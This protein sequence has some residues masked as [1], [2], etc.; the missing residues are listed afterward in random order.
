DPKDDDK[1][2]D[3]KKTAPPIVIDRYHFKQDVEGYLRHER[4]HLYLFDIATK[5]AEV[6]TPG[7]LFDEA[8]PV[9]SPDGTQIAFVSKRGTGDLDRHTN[10]DIWVIDAKAGAQARQVTTS[11][12]PDSSP[13]WSADGK[14]I[15]YLA[16][17]DLK[18]SAYN[19]NKL[20]VVPAA[21]GQP[22]TLAESLDR[23]IRQPVWE[24]GATSLACVVV[25]DRSQYPARVSV[26]DGK[27]QRIVTAKSVITNLSSG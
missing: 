12:L 14:Q 23:P 2:A 11:P 19:Q 6:L 27:V 20:M 26:K 21:G 1:E 8:S 9:W 4:T 15:A 18:Y 25:D 17:E 5:K 7:T 3:K 24:E 16:G 13:A 22:R 10:T